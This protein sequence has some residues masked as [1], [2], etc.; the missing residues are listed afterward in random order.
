MAKLGNLY[1]DGKFP[2]STNRLNHFDRLF[3]QALFG[4]V[5]KTIDFTP[6]ISISD[7]LAKPAIDVQCKITAVQEGSGNPSPQNIRNIVGFSGLSLF[8]GGKNLFD[9]SVYSDYEQEGGYYE[10]TGNQFLSIHISMEDFVGKTITFSA[11]LRK[12]AESSITNIRVCGYING[13]Y[14]NG[15]SV[16][17]E[18][19]T[20][21]SVTITPVTSSDYIC[22]RFGS[23]G[24]NKM[25]A[26]NI[27]LEAGSTATAYAPF[28][29]ITEYP[30]TWQTVAG[31]IYGGILNLIT[32]LLTVTHEILTIDETSSIVFLGNNRIWV[33]SSIFDV[34]F[35]PE[36]ICD[37]FQRGTN[38][39]STASMLNNPNYS[40]C[41]H[42][43]N[44]IGKKS[45][46]VHDE[47]WNDDVDP[48]NSLK[49]WLAD[50]PVHILQKLATPLTYQLSPQAVQLLAG[51]NT[52]W[53][54][55]GDTALTYM[56]KR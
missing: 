34:D 54:T 50:N 23:G 35:A 25:Q 3:G 6:V 12:S 52:L 10:A 38:R 44:A 19:W 18:T 37:T 5:E 45:C 39:D 30:V 43:T 9:D 17:S 47:R 2:I 1:L 20:K 42:L 16:N 24:G 53:N 51:N 8:R 11:D 22:L 27:Q 7:A 55:T 29:E 21:S 14:V 41:T 40:F 31:I 13:S 56:A 48:V 49:A 46:Y 15:N 26:S 36:A 33:V 28:T 4:G 32:G